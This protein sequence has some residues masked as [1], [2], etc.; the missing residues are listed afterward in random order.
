MIKRLIL[1]SLDALEMPKIKKFI[2]ILICEI[3]S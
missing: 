1:I 3:K 2:I